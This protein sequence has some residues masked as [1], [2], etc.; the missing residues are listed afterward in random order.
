MLQPH[1]PATF[2][3]AWHSGPLHARG[4]AA[5]LAHRVELGACGAATPAR[6]SS[7]QS[8]CTL[9]RRC[10][11]TGSTCGDQ[12]TA[13]C[14]LPPFSI[15]PDACKPH[16]LATGKHSVTLFRELA[17]G[18]ASIQGVC[19]CRTGA[20]AD[21]GREGGLMSCKSDDKTTH[22]QQVG[23][24]CSLEIRPRQLTLSRNN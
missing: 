12:A 2:V 4:L 17:R 1:P 24:D 19:P 21:D 7:R 22:K 15:Q 16:S 10:S 3:C 8:A 23:I 14:L 13:S 11:G 18:S 6:Q 9:T 20:A 5:G